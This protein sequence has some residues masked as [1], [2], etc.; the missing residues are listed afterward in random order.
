[1]IQTRSVLKLTGAVVLAAALSGCISLLP[2]TKPSQLYRFGQ[3]T[4]SAPQASAQAGRT[5]ALSVLKARADF[6]RAA[7][8]DRLLTIGPDG[9]AAFAAGAR[10]VAP[11][12]TL[13]DEALE[14]A[15]VFGG[16]V[17][18]INRPDQGPAEVLLRPEVMTFET[19]Y[20]NG[21]EAPPLVVVQVRALVS[22]ADTRALLAERVFDVQVRAADNRLGPIVS[23][24]DQAVNQTLNELVPWVAAAAPAARTAPGL[25]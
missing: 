21:A 3:T 25:R 13:F 20:D 22:R 15:M 10:W 4:A 18:L 12:V 16:G 6:P 19:R 2:K 1:V 7:A 5:A 14:R 11:A 9:Q 23:A 24:Y 8:G 17:R